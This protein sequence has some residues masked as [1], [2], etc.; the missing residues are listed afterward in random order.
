MDKEKK[1]IAKEALQALAD[2]EST[3]NMEDLVKDNK[4][5]W[6]QDDKSYRVRKPSF[7]ERS[8]IDNARRKEY[9][10]PFSK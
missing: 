3:V 8:E 9:L 6:I 1:V 5:E 4:I 7:A 2:I 10:R